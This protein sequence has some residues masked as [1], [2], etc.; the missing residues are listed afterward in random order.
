L[1][2]K[3]NVSEEVDKIKRCMEIPKKPCIPIWVYRALVS[4][5]VG[6]KILCKTVTPLKPIPTAMRELEGNP[7]KR[8]LNLNEPKPEKKA[9]K[10]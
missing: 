5:G 9:F 4:Y 2:Q 7:G 1:R 8:E 10:C 3:E 6:R